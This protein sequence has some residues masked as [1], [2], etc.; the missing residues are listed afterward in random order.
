MTGWDILEAELQDTLEAVRNR[1]LLTPK[2]A[3]ARDLVGE[4]TPP[5]TGCC[6]YCGTPAPR[7][8]VCPAH[9]D[10]TPLDPSESVFVRLAT[11]Q[12]ANRG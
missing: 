3:L 7:R 8:T 4:P 11:T 5:K 10:L 12:G 6:R 1:R 9:E 2:R